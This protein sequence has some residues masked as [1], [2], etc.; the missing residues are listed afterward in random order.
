MNGCEASTNVTITQPQVLSVLSSAAVPVTCN[1]T[2]TGSIAVQAA[3]GTPAYSYNLM[4]GNTTNTSGSFTASPAGTYTVTVT[5]TKGCSITT[6]VTITQPT[7]VA[8]S[9][10]NKTNLLCNGINTGDI[11][12]LASGGTGTITYQ[13]LPAASI[14]TTGLFTSLSANTYTVQATDANNCSISTIVTITQP[15]TISISNIASTLPTCNP[16][17]DG[18]LTVTATGG[19]PSYSYQLNSNA[20]Q[21]GNNFAGLGTGIYT[22][23][24]IDMN[25]CTATS[26]KSL[27]TPNSP[28]IT[29]ATNTNINCNGQN[30][31]TIQVVASGG[32][33]ALNYTLLPNN[34]SNATGTFNSL[35]A[36]NYTVTVTDFNGC[37]V[38]TTINI[39]QPLPL[40]FNSVIT[41]PILCFGGNNGSILATTSGGTGNINYVLQPNNINNA[42]GV[43][44]NLSSTNYTILATDANACSISTVINLLQPTQLVLDS[45]VNPSPTCA[46]SNFTVYAHGGTPPYSYTL[47]N[48]L[49]TTSNYFT[50]ITPGIYTVVVTDANGCSVSTIKSI[51]APNAPIITSLSVKNVS[52]F[53]F[54][55]GLISNIVASGGNGIYTFSILPNN[56]FSNL[57]ANTYAVIVTDGN[58]CTS[59]SIVNITQPTALSTSSITKSDISCHNLTDGSVTV[60]GVGGSG[61]LD[62]KL[63]PN[64]ITNTTGTFANLS[65]G[66]YTVSITDDSSCTY[67]VPLV[68]NNPPALGFLSVAITPISCNG[69]ANA[70]V[71]AIASG[72][73]G[74]NIFSLNPAL[75]LP[76]TTGIFQSLY[77]NTYTIT[78]TDTNGCNK[79]SVFTLNQAPPVSGSFIVQ[80][81]VSC[82]G[83]SN[84]SFIAYA[85]T[86]NSPFTYYLLNST[87][88]NTTGI[89]NNLSAGTYSVQIVDATMCGTIISPIVITQ[90]TSLSWTN[91]FTVN[92]KCSSDLTDSVSVSAAGGTGLITYSISP[93]GPQNNTVGNFNQLSPQTYTVTAKDANNCTIST[94]LKVGSNPPIVFTNISILNP[95]CKGDANGFIKLNTVGGLFP[96]QY[97]INGN[98]Y[99]SNSNF[100][101]L[102]AGNYFIQV[103]D[104]NNCQKDTF[105]NLIDAGKLDINYLNVGSVICN[106]A[107]DATLSIKGTGNYGNI[108]YSLLP[109]SITNS[110]GVFN[111]LAS[112]NYTLIVKDSAGCT[113]DTPVYVTPSM[114]P[115]SISIDSKNLNCIGN[116][117]EGFAEA[118]VTG[119]AQPYNYVWNTNPI[120]TTK[121]AYNLTSGYYIV[122]VADFKG[123]TIADTVYI[124]PGSCCKEVFIPNAFSP[125]GDGMNDQFGVVTSTGLELLQFSVY[126]RLGQQ[127]WKTNKVRE[128]WDGKFNSGACDIGTFY[129]IFSY[130]CL[131]DGN[132]YTLKGDIN[133]IR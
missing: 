102:S 71:V 54:N 76:N 26:T 58:S 96:Y 17:N 8:W 110:T 83:G 19:T 126:N 18:T 3:G 69:L 57:I 97:Q 99:T 55:D 77:A 75:S 40:I 72:G 15:T 81:N 79:D 56:G 68:I 115:L 50:N 46:A 27:V 10:V 109:D 9:S 85:N 107:S 100:V 116:G 59:S 20:Y 31:A 106:N 119:G 117:K 24:V 82:N 122:N 4:P 1:G 108:V 104:F 64:N 61:S 47:N 93:L 14:N 38:Q 113:I 52:C 63:L 37:I 22:V 25:G 80:Q 132:I 87:L 88:S 28:T 65:F 131:F 2:S 62:Y 125:N 49:P 7:A 101:N 30:N 36:N 23:T 95:I 105:I 43:F 60:V 86:G 33:G 91:V 84:G 66:S 12:A 67:N 45:I 129:Y 112:G 103:K 120:Q 13:L 74:G 94:I 44:N 90:P 133:L 34:L 5:D 29:S 41:Q 53:G 127:V 42:T 98:G 78:V 121:E 11:S 35:I 128:R 124:E 130:K 92:L 16:G 111:N 39:T 73:S 118:N 123:C 21:A 51:I 6:N 70:S 114:N 89:F 48:G 32:T